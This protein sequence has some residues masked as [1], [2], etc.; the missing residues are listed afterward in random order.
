MTKAIITNCS[1][2][3]FTSALTIFL[4]LKLEKFRVHTNIVAFNPLEVLLGA[5]RDLQ[6]CLFMIYYSKRKKFSNVEL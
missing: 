3:D 2:I 5:Q 1:M 4:S 6:K